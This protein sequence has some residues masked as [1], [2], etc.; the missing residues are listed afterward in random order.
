MNSTSSTEARIVSV[1][2]ERMSTVTAGGI[3]GLKP[4]QRLLDQIDG[5]DH[6]G[7][8]LLGDDEQNRRLIVVP[9]LRVEVLRTV[10]RVA[11][12]LDPHRPRRCDRR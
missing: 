6:V 8:G 11:D 3:T 5:L 1:R 4:R 9:G 10:D 2:S 7:A 12:V